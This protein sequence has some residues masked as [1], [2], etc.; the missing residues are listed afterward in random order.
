MY[1]RYER[2]PSLIR[3][4][5]RFRGPTERNKYTNFVL[6]TVHDLKLLGSIMDRNE[7]IPGHR[8]HTDFIQDNFVAYFSGEGRPITANI[9]SAAQLLHPKE[10]VFENLNL[11]SADWVSYGNCVKATT[12]RGISLESNGTIDPSGIRAQIPVEEGDIIF[13]RM[14]VRLLSGDGSSFT[15]GSHSINQ[16]EIDVKKFEIP[17]N[18]TTIYVDKR[19]Y[20][21]HRELIS[22]NI[23]V[24]YLPATLKPAKVEIIDVEIRRIS[25]YR[26][27]VQPIN[28]EIKSRINKLEDQIHNLIRNL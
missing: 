22:L 26:L 4:N 1:I 2:R 13:M 17:S 27:T 28:T 10:S 23:D 24:H 6:E 9:G 14:G 11:M 25:E 19:L 21:K 5:S 15:I 16:G 7:Y 20:C 12:N 8:G 3:T 18:G